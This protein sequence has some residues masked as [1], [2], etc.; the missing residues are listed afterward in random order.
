MDQPQRGVVV[1][2]N[3]GE[4]FGRGWRQVGIGSRGNA[5]G[6]GGSSFMIT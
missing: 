1:G 2:L 4:G 6:G 5:K 3:V